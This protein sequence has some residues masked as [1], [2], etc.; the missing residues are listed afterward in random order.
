MKNIDNGTIVRTVVL[1]VALLN[2]SLVLAGYS[3]L[4]FEDQQVENGVTIVLT[5]VASI[6]TWWKNQNITREARRKAAL[7]KREEDAR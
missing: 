4:P 1:F 6:W 2:Q 5:V 3:P 7:I